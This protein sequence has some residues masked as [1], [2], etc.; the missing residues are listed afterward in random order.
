M[1]IL[2]R[3]L[4]KSFNNGFLHWGFENYC[5]VHHSSKTKYSFRLN[6]N[7]EM[8]RS[9]PLREFERQVTNPSKNSVLLIESCFQKH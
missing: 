7:K 9:I 1:K 2:R 5:F 8:N 6:R 4:R 3:C